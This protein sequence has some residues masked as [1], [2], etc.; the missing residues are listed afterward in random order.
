MRTRTL[1]HAG[2]HVA[3]PHSSCTAC[4]DLYGTIRNDFTPARSAKS[5][6]IDAT[7]T[8]YPQEGSPTGLLC[9]WELLEAAAATGTPELVVTGEYVQPDTGVRFPEAGV[10]PAWMREQGFVWSKVRHWHEPSEKC[11]AETAD[12][13]QPIALPA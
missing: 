1:I 9:S 13:Y 2:D 12:H 6:C 11:G 8:A 7:G 10:N 4:R 3:D 5:Y